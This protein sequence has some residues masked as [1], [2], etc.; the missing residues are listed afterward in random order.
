MT[1][2]EKMKVLNLI[3]W[4]QVGV[5][6][7]DECEPIKWFYTKQTKQLLKATGRHHSKGH[8]LVSR[9]YGR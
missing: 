3:M 6:A 5:Y 8:G 4:L 7:A 1:E 9:H 2:D